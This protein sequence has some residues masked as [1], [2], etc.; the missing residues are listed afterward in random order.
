M[1]NFNHMPGP[2]DPETWGP[3]YGH[4]LDPR[5]P[6]PYEPSYEELRDRTAQII[7][8]DQDLFWDTID[9]H[10]DM[11]A[12]FHEWYSKM[13]YLDAT[14]MNQI[15]RDRDIRALSVWLYTQLNDMF[16]NELEEKATEEIRS[17]L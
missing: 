7:A 15:A 17:E 16:L 12:L 14:K 6:D 1:K 2:G 4:P 3:C 5:T 8:D 13:S 9:K 11:Y 10:P